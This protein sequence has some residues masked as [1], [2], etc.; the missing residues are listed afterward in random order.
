MGLCSAELDESKRNDTEIIQS[1]GTPRTAS[2][3]NAPVVL[4]S[5]RFAR[6][7][8]VSPSPPSHSTA[9]FGHLDE[10]W[11]APLKA[12]H[13]DGRNDRHPG[14]YRARAMPH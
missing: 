3:I 1:M 11:L 2:N 13:D 9:A 7:K 12:Q 4:Y 5:T 6:P 14:S 8:N 10:T